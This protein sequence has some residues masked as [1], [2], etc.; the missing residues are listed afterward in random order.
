MADQ[1]WSPHVV[2]NRFEFS[3]AGGGLEKSIGATKPWKGGSASRFGESKPA[4]IAGLFTFDDVEVV[5]VD[6]SAAGVVVALD[7][8]PRFGLSASFASFLR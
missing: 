4:V 3:R 6:G 5:D 7:G 1:A 2:D 8:R